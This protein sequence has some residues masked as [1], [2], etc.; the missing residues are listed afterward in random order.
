MRDLAARGE[1]ISAAR[2]VNDM[3]KRNDRRRE[4]HGGESC[5]DTPLS[6]KSLAQDCVLYHAQMARALVYSWYLGLTKKHLHSYRCICDRQRIQSLCG[7]ASRCNRSVAI[8]PAPFEAENVSCCS[9][10]VEERRRL[11]PLRPDLATDFPA[12][13]AAQGPAVASRLLAL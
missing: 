3:M 6:W 10:N 5:P 8:Q 2:W 13:D 1:Y 7:E 12:C 11:H 4:C 9:A